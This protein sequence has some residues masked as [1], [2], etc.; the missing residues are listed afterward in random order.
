MK[1]LWRQQESGLIEALV[2]VSEL[3]LYFL[4]EVGFWSKVTMELPVGLYIVTT[5]TT[6]HA[7]GLFMLRL[8][9]SPGL[10]ETEWD[11][12]TPNFT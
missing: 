3:E 5:K 12:G 6:S 4:G 7:L 11:Y 8:M 2:I 1:C 10:P 9:E